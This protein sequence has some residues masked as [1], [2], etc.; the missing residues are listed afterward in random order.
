MMKKVKRFFLA[1]LLLV[2]ATAAWA[3]DEIETTISGDVVSSYI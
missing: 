1:G 2:G 3:Q